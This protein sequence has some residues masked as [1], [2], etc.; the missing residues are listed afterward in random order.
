MINAFIPARQGSKRI[1]HKN[2]KDFFGNPLMAYAIQ[3]A[4]DSGVFDNIYVTSDSK[5]YLRIADKLGV[6]GI[7]RPEELADGD[8]NEW[9]K[10]ALETIK[11][12]SKDVYA[13]LPPTNPFRTI[14]TIQEAFEEFEEHGRQQLKS[15]ELCKQH[16][17]KMFYHS[18]PFI[19]SMSKNHNKSYQDLELFY[20][21][22]GCIYISCAKQPTFKNKL[23]PFY[24]DGYE[25]FDIN[26]EEDWIL[27]EELVKRELIKLPEVKHEYL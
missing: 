21:Q 11:A 26:V 23:I 9:V 13:V 22:N 3:T 12:K 16:P 8:M 6:K 4:K 15:V 18:Y 2:I 27:A 25:G 17:D 19:K 7:L 5:E 10:H 14:K 1:P 20:V 24:T